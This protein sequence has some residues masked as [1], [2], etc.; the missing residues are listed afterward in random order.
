MTPLCLQFVDAFFQLRYGPGCSTVV[1]QRVILG[2]G[3]QITAMTLSL[4]ICRLKNHGMAILG[5]ALVTKANRA[6]FRLVAI[7]DFSVIG[8]RTAETKF[9]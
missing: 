9:F 8:P 4:P 3:I 1:L 2:L 5:N 6:L 7:G